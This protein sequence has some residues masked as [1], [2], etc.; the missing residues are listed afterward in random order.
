MENIKHKSGNWFQK[1]ESHLDILHILFSSAYYHCLQLLLR[2]LWGP[3][4]IFFFFAC[5]NNSSSLSS[6]VASSFLPWSGLSALR[7][8]SSSAEGGHAQFPDAIACA[9][10][11]NPLA[12]LCSPSY[13]KAPEII[14]EHFTCDCPLIRPLW[15]SEIV[16]QQVSHNGNSQFSP[17]MYL[18]AAPLSRTEVHHVPVHK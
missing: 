17:L 13:S 1:L 11:C 12:W 8:G 15:F 5:H 18:I 10:H 14:S 16:F 6:A 3:P 9:D 4:L 2:D 7:S